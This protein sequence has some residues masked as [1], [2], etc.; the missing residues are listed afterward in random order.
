MRPKGLLFVGHS[1]NFSESRD[2]FEL[3]GKTIYHRV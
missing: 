3:R 1:E 2:L